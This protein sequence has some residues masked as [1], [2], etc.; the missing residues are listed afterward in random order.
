[1]IPQACKDGN[2]GDNAYYQFLLAM[3]CILDVLI[4]ISLAY[5]IFRTCFNKTFRG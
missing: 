2:M 1:M 4:P 5:I 3:I